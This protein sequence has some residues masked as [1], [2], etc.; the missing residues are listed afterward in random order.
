MIG[1]YTLFIMIYINFWWRV[2]LSN[3]EVSNIDQLYIIVL[4]SIENC[5]RKLSERNTGKSAA[6]TKELNAL[7][8]V[9]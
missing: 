2:K 6:L 4:G 3:I 9:W 7:I 5:L 1:K 8:K